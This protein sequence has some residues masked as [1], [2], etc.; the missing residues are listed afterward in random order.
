M[1]ERIPNKPTKKEMFFSGVYGI[2]CCFLWL[3]LILGAVH[4]LSY[5]VFIIKK[6]G[7]FSQESIKIC[8]YI[9][10]G[11]FMFLFIYRDEA[12]KIFKIK[13][14]SDEKIKCKI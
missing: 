8:T 5:Y 11:A 10:I 9:I 3:L 2:L 12:K 13:E 6:E 1:K 14:C 4:L 7:F